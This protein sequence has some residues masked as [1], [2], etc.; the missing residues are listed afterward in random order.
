MTRLRPLRTAPAVALLTAA[1][2]SS[3]AGVPAWA[4]EPTPAPAPTATASEPE[5]VDSAPAPNPDPAPEPSSPAPAPDAD[6]APEPSSPAPA[7]AP[8]VDPSAPAPAASEPLSPTDPALG[9]DSSSATGPTATVKQGE[10]SESSALRT[11]RTSAG[12][13]PVLDHGR[14]SLAPKI[15]PFAGNPLVVETITPGYGVDTEHW[16]SGFNGDY[17][18]QQF[19]PAGGAVLNIPAADRADDGTYTTPGMAL[20]GTVGTSGLTPVDYATGENARL[21]LQTHLLNG[22]ADFM[23]PDAQA[24]I[25]RRST[26]TTDLRP[27]TNGYLALT[28]AFTPEGAH[29]TVTG[30]GP[31]G[32][33]TSAGWDTRTLRSDPAQPRLGMSPN[34]SIYALQAGFSAPGVYCLTIEMAPVLRSSGNQ[35]APSTATYTV[36]AGDLPATVPMC[37]AEGRPDPVPGDGGPGTGGPAEKPV[38]VFATGHVDVRAPLANDGGSLALLID[39]GT[40]GR[41]PFRDVVTSGLEQTTVPSPSAASDLSAIAPAGS[42]LWFWSEG[43]GNSGTHLWPGVSGQDFV[44]GSMGPYASQDLSLMEVRGPADGSFALYDSRAV[45]ERFDPSSL[46]WSTR[47][48]MPQ[49]LSVGPANHR[50]FT[51]AFTAEGKYCLAIN[52]KMLKGDGTRVGQDARLTV[53]VGDPAK[54][55][56]QVPCDR[57]AGLDGLAM[58]SHGKEPVAVTEPARKVAD[59]GLVALEPRLDEGKIAVGARVHATT[60]A[61]ARDVDPSRIVISSS[62]RNGTNYVF[63]PDGAWGAPGLRFSTDRLDPAGIVGEAGVSL[64]TVIGPGT[65]T[66]ERSTGAVLSSDPSAGRTQADLAPR[67]LNMLVWSFSAP[68]VYCVPLT[69]SAVPGVTAAASSTTTTLT[70]AVG[71]TTPGETDYVNRDAVV[72]CG[73][74]GTGTGPSPA[75]TPK[76]TPDPGTGTQP[77]NVTVIGAGHLDLASRQLGGMF[78]TQ[79]KDSSQGTVVYRDPAKTVLQVRDAARRPV[80]A[81]SP[82]GFIGTEGSTAYVLGQSEEA[83]LIWPGWSTEEVPEAGDVTW[84]LKK[85]GTT[86]SEDAAPGKMA[87]YQLGTFGAAAMK[88]NTTDGTNQFTI[89]AGVHQHGTWVFS[90]P[91]VYCMAFNRT[92]ATGAS[93]D[94]TVAWAVG[95]SV[96][97]SRVDPGDCFAGK[98]IDTIDGG[99]KTAPIVSSSAVPGAAGGRAVAGSP[100]GPGTVCLPGAP[101]K[102]GGAL[103][104]WL[105]EPETGKASTS[106]G[107]GIATGAAVISAGHVDYATR[108]IDGRLRSFLKDGTTAVPAWREPGEVV[109]NVGASAATRIPEGAFGFLGTPGA[110]VYQLP[111]TQ[112]AGLP[113]LG[114]NTQSLGS[115]V[116]GPVTWSLDNVS[117]PGAVT[118]YELGAFGEPVQLLSPGRSLSV[119]AGVHAHATWAFTAAGQYRLTMTQSATLANG[120]RSSDTQLVSVMVGNGEAP[121]AGERVAGSVAGLGNPTAGCLPAGSLAATASEA[122]PVSAAVTTGTRPVAGAASTGDLEPS[123]DEVPLWLWIAMGGGLMLLGAGVGGGTVWFLRRR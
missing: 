26:A 100:V 38:T 41:I 72:P 44:P 73:S 65:V 89:P 19:F 52:A 18:S 32:V 30:R 13:L 110:I 55:K 107:A 91:G 80:T 85:L 111:Q 69:F 27:S 48:G 121:A 78:T 51:W 90:K 67:S 103:P 20:D 94:F 71:S 93:S 29:A 25:N 96:E 88:F 108:V 7:P 106:A 16:G 120:S 101:A 86:G 21:F 62:V 49:S 36:V 37:S 64:G 79:V 70:I 117:G 81:G 24:E 17:R 15:N 10:S 123:S 116:V 14:V 53:W 56:D 8:S 54:A 1:L 35:P 57:P 74:G 112:A 98:S 75:P 11:V 97:V 6:P 68:G 58:L 99:V 39:A 105:E 22:Q 119:P 43:G 82:F 66:A 5:P 60:T 46:L 23:I 104:G 84:T 4:T 31:G 95:E 114:W 2:L 63:G 109:L 83:G 47:S 102:A 59:T 92:A 118:I 34:N 122:S 77:S 33:A 42:P 115:D 3:V 61:S 12:E 50:H 76:P 28:G 9:A 87:L 113:W 40:Y 45:T